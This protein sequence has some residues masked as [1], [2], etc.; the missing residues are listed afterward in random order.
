[1]SI[2]QIAILIEDCPVPSG[3]VVRLVNV[4]LSKEE[5]REQ[6]W[7]VENSEMHDIHCEDMGHQERATRE[8]AE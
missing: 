3:F 1:V 5:F 8:A 7:V 6:V 2:P 4:Q